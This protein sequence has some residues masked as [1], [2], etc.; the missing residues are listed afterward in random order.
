VCFRGAG[1]CRRDPRI[2]RQAEVVVAAEDE[3]FATVDD[4]DGRIVEPALDDAPP[5]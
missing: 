4:G 1:Q 2:A 3:A 5:A